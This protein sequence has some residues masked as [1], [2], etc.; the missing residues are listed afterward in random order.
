MFFQIKSVQL[1]Y[2][3]DQRCNDATMIML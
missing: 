2:C 3:I 1:V